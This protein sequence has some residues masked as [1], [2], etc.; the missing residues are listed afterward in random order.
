MHSE[1]CTQAKAGLALLMLIESCVHSGAWLI[2]KER[3]GLPDNANGAE[4]AHLYHHM[5]WESDFH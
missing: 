3:A 1:E 4:V 5:G 2:P